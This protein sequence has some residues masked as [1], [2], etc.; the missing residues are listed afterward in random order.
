MHGLLEVRVELEHSANRLWIS[1]IA[2]GQ[3]LEQLVALTVGE[4]AH[5]RFHVQQAL[6][7]GGKRL[8]AVW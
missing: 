8:R 2:V 6:Q 7:H 3:I 1:S 4:A 5:K